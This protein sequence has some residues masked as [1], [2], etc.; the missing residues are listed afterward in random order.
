MAGTLFWCFVFNIVMVSQ[1]K[2]ERSQKSEQVVFPCNTI[3]LFTGCVLLNLRTVPGRSVWIWS[4]GEQMKLH[5]LLKIT[6]FILRHHTLISVQHVSIPR[7]KLD[8]YAKMLSANFVDPHKFV[9]LW[10][11][12]LD[13]PQN[14]TKIPE[15]Y[16]FRD[17]T[18][19]LKV[20]W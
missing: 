15:M 3:Q 13:E 11:N 14:Y 10:L 2:I 4:H 17:L 6:A 18:H 1:E 12:K 16:H 5:P 20:T 7:G 8:F 19:P 9:I